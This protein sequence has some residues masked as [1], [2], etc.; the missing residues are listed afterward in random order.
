MSKE[1]AGP[2][3]PGIMEREAAK[4]TAKGTAQEAAN[5]HIRGVIKN[6]EGIFSIVDRTRS[7]AVEKADNNDPANTERISP[8]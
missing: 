4:T 1:E 7:V 5:R 6:T 8:K 3:F 2:F